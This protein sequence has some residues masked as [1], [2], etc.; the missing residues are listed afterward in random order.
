MAKPTLLDLTQSILNAM[1]S[2]NVNSVSDT[3]ESEQVANIIKEVYFELITERNLANN[4]SLFQLTGLA[5]STQPTKMLIPPKVSDV[6][7]VKYNYK[8]S[9]DSNN[10]TTIRYKTPEEFL[11]IVNNRNSTLTEA[12]DYTDS[13]SGVVITIMNN[14]FP[15][16]WTTF[17]DENITFDS[18]K[19]T[20]ESTLTSART[21]CFG[22][23]DKDWADFTITDT[24][25]PDLPNSLFPLLLSTAKG[26]CFSQVKQMPD[27]D[28]ERSTRRLRISQARED[29]RVSKLVLIGLLLIME[30]SN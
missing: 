27:A 20:E 25:T 4:E 6:Q 11:N 19:S 30:E 1:D 7:V 18:Y 5:D 17:D 23:L 8:E 24:F 28:T 15:T 10:F 21:Q 16:Y 14:A 9:T 22:I 2:D 12:E 26:R 3:V 13:A 29:H